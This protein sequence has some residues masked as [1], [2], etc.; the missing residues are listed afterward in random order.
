MNT[1]NEMINMDSRKRDCIKAIELAIRHMDINELKILKT[2]TNDMAK[3]YSE[4]YR[5]L[6]ETGTVYSRKE[7]MF[8]YCSDPDV[9]RKDNKCQL[10]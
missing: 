6:I 9:C 10:G 2:L 5:A 1:L 4:S 3:T 8:N 7:C